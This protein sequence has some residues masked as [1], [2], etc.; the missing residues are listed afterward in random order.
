MQKNATSPPPDYQLN[1]V[2]DLVK[3]NQ[4]N[5]RKQLIINVAY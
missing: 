5:V 2:S 4:V 1:T 3:S